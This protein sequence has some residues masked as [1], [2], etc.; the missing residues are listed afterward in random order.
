MRRVM[1]SR[2]YGA[3]RRRERGAVAIIVA[4]SLVALIGFVGLV[5]DLGKLYV[6]K[7][8]LQNSADACALAAARDLTGATPLSVSEAAGI[9]AAHANSAFFQST[10]VS[11]VTDSTVLYSDSTSDTFESKDSITYSLANIKYAQCTTQLT[12][13]ANWFVQV[14]GAL[15]GMSA[16][17][18]AKL[19]SSSVSAAAVATVGAAQT[20]CAIPV[21]VCTPASAGVSSY[22]IGQWLTS[23][24]D[25]QGNGTYGGG[26]FG[27]ANLTP[28]NS[29]ASSLGSLLSGAGQC[30]LPANG[31]Q[32]GTTGNKSSLDKDWNTRF[33]IY[34]GG[35][36]GVTD[37]TGY[38]YTTA[39]NPNGNAYPDFVQE[40][41]KYAPYQ[42]D[43]VTGYKTQGSPSAQSV[44][45]AGADRRLV[46]APMVDCTGFTNP[47]THQVPVNGWACV[48]MV[49]P[50]QQ[51]GDINAVFL[52]YLGLSN[53]AGSPCATQG[54]PGAGTGAGPL[55][56]VLVQ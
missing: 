53:S 40:R 42:G 14:F 27:W 25:S 11:A 32:I 18:A 4:L 51:G 21:F 34:A 23:K 16:A 35:S 20:T 50:M 39:S 6:T 56:P 44:Y 30:S 12:G 43:N 9:A 55:V 8:E 29:G 3:A 24:V 31:T 41:T 15:P 26:N 52:E 28:G 46:L 2:K 49:N 48:L 54:A 22:T 19:A 45:K 36:T 5:L 17:N 37:F 7:S 10:A 33:G 13:I 1:Q 47:G 38:A